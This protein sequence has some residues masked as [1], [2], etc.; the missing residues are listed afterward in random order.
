MNLKKAKAIKDKT[1]QYRN[2]AIELDNQH[3]K[4]LRKEV[5]ESVSS[6]KMHLEIMGM[7]NGFS[8][9]RIYTFCNISPI[10]VTS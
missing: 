9:F 3:F 7:L 1:K 5:E 10:I 2:F 6:S 4:R 8:D